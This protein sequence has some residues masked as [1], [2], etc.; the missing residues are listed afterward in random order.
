[1]L[2]E[3]KAYVCQ[4]NRDLLTQGLV[5][6]TSGNVSARDPETNLLVIKPSGVA[7]DQLTPEDMSVVDLHGNVMEGPHKP[8]VDTASHAYVYRHR[9]DIHG[10][11][12]THSAY[13]TS[14]ALRGET[15]PVLT[16]THACLFGAEIPITGYAVI[17]EEEIGREIVEHVGDGTSV[18][19]R[20][21]GVFTIGSDAAK[22]LRSALYTEECAEA[23]HL[24][25]TRGPVQPLSD[26]VVAAA[27]AW[28]LSDY[29]Q[30]PIGSG[31]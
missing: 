25:M 9:E 18:L 28:Y 2:D 15:I 31:S 1:M 12:H 16:T 19:M 17:G 5:V 13:A 23:A 24:G 14:F 7:F 10:V 27:R 3:L 21:H 11:V 29:G 8:S 26:E 22:A 6:G 30:K 4:L 20:S